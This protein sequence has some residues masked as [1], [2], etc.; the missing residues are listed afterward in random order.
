MRARNTC[1]DCG[2]QSPETDT[3]FSLVSAEHG[4][5][6]ATRRGPDGGV[7]VEWR[8]PTCWQAYKQQR[9]GA[10]AGSGT[11]TSNAGPVSRPPPRGGQGK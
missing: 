2:A 8:C 11:S 10:A 7:I 1:V 3:N 5:R 6:F 4:W 9:Q